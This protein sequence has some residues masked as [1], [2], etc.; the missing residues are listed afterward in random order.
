MLT[1]FCCNE[2]NGP[3]DKAVGYIDRVRTRAGLPALVN[4][5]Y[6]S[7][8][9]V[10]GSKDAFRDHI[11]I[12]RALELACE[13]VRWFDLKRWGID[14]KALTELKSRDADFNNFVIGRSIRVPIPQTDVD[15]NPNLSQNPNY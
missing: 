1:C 12:E 9:S 8:T 14:E 3:S 2:L 10:K 11:K 6:Y 13:C 5:G 4:S 7:L 15:N